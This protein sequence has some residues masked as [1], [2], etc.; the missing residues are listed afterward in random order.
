MDLTTSPR[1]ERH[2]NGGV[3]WKAYRTIGQ[4]HPVL[5]WL[6]AIPDALMRTRPLLCLVYASALRFTDQPVAAEAR[7]QDAERSIQPD[8]APDQARLIQGRVAAIRANIARYTGD[9][10][11]C[12]ALAEQALRLLPE[13]EL[14]PRTFSMLN[15]ARAFRVSG[16]MTDAQERRAIAVVAPIRATGNLLGSLVAVANLA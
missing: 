6:R 8:T 1:K 11:T 12:I 16:D 9:L 7:L 3:Y 15:V 4:V 13:T 5:G 10:V 2:V 14:I